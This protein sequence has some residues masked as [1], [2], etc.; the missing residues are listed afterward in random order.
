MSKSTNRMG[1]A[2]GFVS[3]LC[4]AG[5][6]TVNKYIYTNYDITAL[7]YS[8]FF[9]VM[10]AVFAF[11]SLVYKW[12]GESLVT[13][14]SNLKSFV[15]LAVAGFLAVSIFTFGLNF[16]STVNAALLVTTTIVATS[17]FSHLI[18]G[19]RYARKQWLWVAV[20]FV[21]LYIAIVGFRRIFLQKG[22]LIVLASV[23]FFG[24]GNAFSRKVMGR[25]K[26]PGIV[27]DSRLVLSAIIA[28]GVLVVTQRNYSIFID[29]L[30]FGLLAGFFY[31]ACMKTFAWCVH[32]LNAN[33]A[34][35]LNNTQIF[36]TSIA[37]V[38][39]LSEPYSIEKF[40]GSVIVIVSVYF[41][42][43]RQRLKSLE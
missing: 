8:M 26:K 33:E 34:I 6:L 1:T 16:T 20:L 42:S 23:L 3:A 15:V 19:E 18:L 7:Q 17:I 27:P 21:G 13:V 36:F 11:I 14:R 12:D 41:I 4:V 29:I 39:A 25:L 30:P 37:G 35:V 43:A 38:L 40:L 2:S 32:L 24:F 10:G 31:W 22:D 28:I 5:Y 9:A